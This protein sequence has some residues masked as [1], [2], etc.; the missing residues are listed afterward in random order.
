MTTVV[1][2]VLESEVKIIT[3]SA[4]IPGILDEYNF[5][6]ERRGLCLI[7]NNH[8]FN[9]QLTNQNDREGTEVDAAICESTFMRLG[10]DVTRRDDLTVTEMSIAVRQ[11]AEENHKD[12]D[13]FACVILSHGDDG[14]IYGTNGTMRI[15]RLTANFK[16]DI[17]TDLRGKPKLFFIQACRG[18]RYDFGTELDSDMT[19]SVDS[20]DSIVQRI[21][22]EAD[23]LMAFSVVPGHFSW[24]NNVDGSWFIQ[25]L[26]RVLQQHSDTVELM[27]LMTLVN[28]LVAYEFQSCTD[29]EFTSNMKQMPSM[30]STLTKLAYFKP[31]Y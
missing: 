2:G 27:H 23:F 12:A 16:G 8:H 21:P 14:V 18:R 28:K 4:A 17:C 26:C 24:R 11:A 3:R 15:D 31:K 20:V 29:S 19:D 1:D 30:V 7:I 5:S 6:H 9:K 10:F 13:C 22:V 25:A